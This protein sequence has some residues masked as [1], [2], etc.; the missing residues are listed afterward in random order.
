MRRFEIWTGSLGRPVQSVDTPAAVLD[1]G[2]FDEN[3]R[4][5]HTLVSGHQRTWRAH[6][7]AHK[8]SF[9]AKRQVEAGAV[10]VLV[11]KLGEAEAMAKGGV[12]DVYISN[13]VVD[14]EK[15]L[16]VASLADRCVLSIAVDS[17]L[18]L[19][20]LQAA[21]RKQ[22]TV[23][24]VRVLVDVN[25]GHNRCGASLEEAVRVRLLF[26]RMIPLTRFFLRWPWPEW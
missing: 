3:N 15:L 25:V 4:N 12:R 1:L 10:G 17:R 19:A 22:Q 16:R 23:S 14:E 24:K 13:E 7:K 26:G 5:M 21:L 11:Q 18:G 2:A 6:A 8:S 20:R 9:L